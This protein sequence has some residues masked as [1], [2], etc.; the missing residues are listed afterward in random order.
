MKGK[1]VLLGTGGSMGVPVIA[2]S[3]P[4]CLSS[5]VRN[6]R[7]R[8][9]ALICVDDKT[10][11]IDAGPEIRQQLLAHDIERLD[12]ALI[13]H[14]HFDHIAAIDDLKA[15]TFVHKRKLA[16]LLSKE[17][18][19]ELSHRHYYLMDGE[20]RQGLHFDFE[21]VEPPFKP[22]VFA[23]LD[24]KL[25]S[26]FQREM[27]VLG[28]KIGDL[29][30]VSDIK[31]Y[32]KELIEDIKGIETLIV[33]ALRHTSSPMHFSIDEAIAFAIEVG[34]KTTYFTHMAHEIDYDTVSAALPDSIHLGYDGLAIPFTYMKELS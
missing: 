28:F 18:F 21:V 32:T 25:L 3:C 12:G 11:L 20:G 4:V 10:L 31:Q 17:S 2:C 34:A 7:N 29:A 15:F 27:P 14:A 1:I 8:S 13:T 24:I 23:G 22:Q 33:S 9:A 30:Y 5:S 16:V 26:Y 19:E 6:K